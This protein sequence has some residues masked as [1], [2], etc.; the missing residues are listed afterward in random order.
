MDNDW[1]LS[2]CVL[3]LSDTHC[4]YIFISELVIQTDGSLLGNNNITAE[5]CLVL[6]DTLFYCC[7]LSVNLSILLRVLVMLLRIMC[8]Y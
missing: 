6:S 5:V 8:Y 7:F 3:V 2:R 4:Y 1:L